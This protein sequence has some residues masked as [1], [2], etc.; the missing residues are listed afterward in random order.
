MEK[1]KVFRFRKEKGKEKEILK[2]NVKRVVKVSEYY[3]LGY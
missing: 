1:T 2:M 3:Y